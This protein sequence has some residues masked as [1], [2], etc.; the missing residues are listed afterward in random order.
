VLQ[1][2]QKVSEKNVD[3]QEFSIT[4]IIKRKVLFSKRPILITNL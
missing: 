4:G 1:R 3:N 2:N